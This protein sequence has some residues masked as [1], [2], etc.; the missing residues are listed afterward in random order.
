MT[1]DYGGY[2]KINGVEFGYEFA[3]PHKKPYICIRHGN[4][5]YAYG[6]FKDENYARNFFTELCDAINKEN[7][8]EEH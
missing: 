1:E 5:A 2:V 8:N 7:W 6:Q 3:P 4:V